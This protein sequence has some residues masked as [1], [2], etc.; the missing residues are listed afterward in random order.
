[1]IA[2]NVGGAIIPAIDVGSIFSLTRRLW[3]HGAIATATSPL[4]LYWL[5]NPVPGLGIAVPV[6]FP[7]CHR[8][9]RPAAVAP[10]T[11]RRSPISPAAWAR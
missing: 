7:A 2:V 1:M 6:F 10:R 5:A 11:P 3:V 9:G 4:V 8:G